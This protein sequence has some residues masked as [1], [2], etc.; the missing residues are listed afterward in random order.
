MENGH[1]SKHKVHLVYS[2]HMPNCYF[3][4]YDSALYLDFSGHLRS[5]AELPF[6]GLMSVLHFFK[7]P[8]K[9]LREGN[10]YLAPTLRGDTGHHGGRV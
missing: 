9:K 7:Y 5:A 8:K 3:I 4:L 10:F 6:C 2:I 1:K